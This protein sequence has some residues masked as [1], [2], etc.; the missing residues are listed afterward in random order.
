MNTFVEYSKEIL[1]IIMNGLKNGV[2][3]SAIADKLV[4]EYGFNRESALTIITGT[5]LMINQT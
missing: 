5:I 4:N 1:T 3:G 2:S